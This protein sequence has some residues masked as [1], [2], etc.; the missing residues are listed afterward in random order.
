MIL[1]DVKNDG[2]VTTVPMEM[3]QGAVLA[4]LVVVTDAKYAF[5][6][7][8]LVPPSG[9]YIP[10][11][12]FTRV[13]IDGVVMWKASLP[14]DAA[15][16][17][18][19]ITY[20]IFLTDSTGEVLETPEG[21]ITIPESIISDMPETVG[22]LEQ[23]TINELY[24]LLA[25]VHDEMEENDIRLDKLERIVRSSRIEIDP[26]E[27]DFLWSD[28]AKLT[29]QLPDTIEGYDY[30]AILIADDPWT[31]KWAQRLEMTVD[32][33]TVNGK[34]VTAT[35]SREPATGE[36][37][38]EDETLRFTC[39]AFLTPAQGSATAT[40]SFVGM[41][42]FPKAVEGQVVINTVTLSKTAWEDTFYGDQ[43]M[44]F[45]P[46][47]GE[48]EENSYN[49]A[50]A[51]TLYP[52]DDATRDESQRLGLTATAAKYSAGMTYVFL[53]KG[54]EIPTTNMRFLAVLT[55]ADAT[56]ENAEAVVPVYVAG[57]SSFP[58][59]TWE[60]EVKQVVDAL[61]PRISVG[62][63]TIAS[64]QWNDSDPLRADLLTTDFDDHSIVLLIPMDADTRRESQRIEVTVH[65]Y[66]GEDNYGH[67]WLLASQSYPP[68]TLT[69]ESLIIKMPDPLPEGFVPTAAIVGVSE[70]SN[71]YM[72]REVLSSIDRNL[73]AI[74]GKVLGQM[75]VY[76][77][78]VADV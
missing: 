48:Y 65:S 30:A 63:H 38:L 34:G 37:N 14:P 43:V 78:E 20:Q 9:L 22:E 69:Y 16:V 68:P 19:S 35:I 71:D 42:N 70:L 25:G 6:T 36:E 21:H 24:A 41:A 55:G 56:N 39:V 44:V 27:N 40:A 72:D 10:D 32:S 75:P 7:M 67:I 46:N 54:E 50:A 76:N 31:L 66:S 28:N 61:Y 1:F 12:I 15:M 53:K 60:R 49:R 5:V 47:W 59:E 29:I 23:H 64:S 57:V 26:E 77:G 13:K 33:V 58:E 74:A 45:G 3:A 4:D 18:G 62:V 52:L 73:D 8:R 2:T 17:E 11:I 51:I